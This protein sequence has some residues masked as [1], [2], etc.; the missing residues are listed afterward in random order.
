MVLNPSPC[1]YPALHDIPL[2][3]VCMERF[4]QGSCKMLRCCHNAL[5]DGPPRSFFLCFL[6]VAV[7]CLGQS[8]CWQH[9]PFSPKCRWRNTDLVRLAITRAV[10]IARHRRAAPDRPCPKS[11]LARL[12]ITRVVIIA[13][14]AATVRN[15]PCPNRGPA[16]RV[17]TRVA[18]IA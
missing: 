15:R 7:S 2:F 14:P 5:Q 13:W 10:I 3:G 6:F 1:I 11:V 8:G 4:P 18:I 12:D 9:S 17:I 16:L